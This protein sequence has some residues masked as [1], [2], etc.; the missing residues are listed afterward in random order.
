MNNFWRKL[1]M[2]LL[3]DGIENGRVIPT[4]GAKKITIDGKTEEYQVYKID[5]SLLFYNDQNDRI[6]T[7]INKHISEGNELPSNKDEFNE[8][9]EDFIVRSNPNAI[10]ETK[11]NIE[12]VDQREPGVVLNDGRVIDGNRRFTCLRKLHKE[13]PL[14]FN[15]FEA[16]ILKKDIEKNRKQ[17]KLLELMI[18][19]GEE[20]KIDYDPIDKLVGLYN[21]V[22]KEKLITIDE[23]IEST[24]SKRNTVS[25]KINEAKLMV[26][27]LDYINQPE[28]FYIARDLNLD[29]PLM[30]LV[31]ILKKTPEDRKE[32]VKNAVFNILA[33]QK[34]GDLTRVVRRVKT[35]VAHP[36]QLETFVEEQQNIA[37]KVQD[38]VLDTKNNNALSDLHGN[39]DLKEEIIKS[40]DKADQG[41]KLE[42][43]K[44]A[45][46]QQVIKACDDLNL[47][48]IDLL[49][50]LNEENMHKFSS[51]LDELTQIIDR[52]KKE[53]NAK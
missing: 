17:I 12:R 18:Q 5:L 23:Y 13:N 52:L 49:N 25:D 43:L 35:I 3:K 45:P 39:E 22:V 27:F 4:G 8:L 46:V 30:E 10:K 14:K 48:N 21:D 7:W 37:L 28:K 40:I 15:Y 51:Y 6:A 2:N 26:E 33:V 34:G 41:S 20:A 50:K 1:K 44:D 16:V 47:I 38:I 36:T 31:G 19:H 24:N 29:G 9:I 11:T 53:T 32:E 42:D